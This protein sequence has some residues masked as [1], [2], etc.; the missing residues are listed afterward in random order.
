MSE[1]DNLPAAKKMQMARRRIALMQPFF[2]AFLLQREVVEGF[3]K[4]VNIP[5]GIKTMCTDGKTI[6]YDSDFVDSLTYSEAMAVLYHEVLHIT[7]RHHLRRD[8]RNPGKWNVACDYVI[9]PIIIQDLGLQMPTF[10]KIIAKLGLPMP[11]KDMLHD[12]N[13]MKYA[14]WTAEKVYEDLPDMPSP[15]CIGVVIDQKNGDGSDLSDAERTM[16][17]LKM[18]EQTIL[19]AEAAKAV[20]KL[21]GSLKSIIE[22]MSEPKVDW[23]KHVRKFV[24]G[25]E[26]EEYSTNRPNRGQ[27]WEYGMI[28]PSVEKKGIGTLGIGI[29]VSGSVSDKELEQFATEIRHISEELNPT[30]I[31]VIQCDAEI[32]DIKEYLAGDHFTVL[33]VKGRG[34]T[35]VRPV[36]DW[37]EANAPDMEK[38]IYLTDCGVFD[39]GDAP[40]YEILWVST[41]KGNVPPYGEVTY[42]EV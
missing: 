38:A 41:S 11:D 42:I 9:D 2:A 40:S 23:A 34:G 17:E 14:G 1:N 4:G 39:Y 36:L 35:R 25:T 19:A 30:K 20:G 12:H 24:G 37:L 22:A 15:P 16:E 6:W 10:D 26:P 13:E 32:R 27:Y 5:G 8:D 3:P 7:L 33:K 21:P 18:E 29:D 28:E 31:I